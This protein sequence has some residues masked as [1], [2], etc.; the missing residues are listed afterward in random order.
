[1]SPRATSRRWPGR[2]RAPSQ[3][4]QAVLRAAELHLGQDARVGR[5]TSPS[6]TATRSSARSPGADGLKTGHTEEAGYGFTGSAEQNGRRLIEVVAGLGS[7]NAARP[8]IDAADAVGLQRLAGQ[9]LVPV[10]RQGR[11]GQGPA[12]QRAAR[13]RWSR[14]AIS[15]SR[16]P[17][18][19]R[20]ARPP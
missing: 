10:G 13:S 3:P 7:W 4:L 16:C 12:G 17:R 15:P 19:S 2:D 8:G 5:R 9:A 18:A 20:A 6:R 14:R 1:M 11:H